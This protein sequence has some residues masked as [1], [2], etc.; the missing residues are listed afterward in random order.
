[1]PEIHL[2]AWLDQLLHVAL[3][4][5][6][7]LLAYLALRSTV[8]LA[9]RHLLERRTDP[10]AGDTLSA[11][12][13]ERRVRTLERLTL[14]VAA[15]VIVIIAG[16]MVLSPFVDIGPAVAGFGVVG[17]AVGFGAQ[18][19]IKDWLA[20]IFVIIE[21]QYSQGDVVRIAGVDGV[22]E[23]FSLRRTVLRDLNGTV[24][25]VPNGQITV[26]SNMTR[27]WARVNLDVTVG[28]GTDIDL[29]TR[30]IND[31]GARLQADPEWAPRMLEAPTVVRVNELG[32]NGITLK[33]LG[34]VRAAEQWTV[35]GELRKRVLAV[36]AEHGIKI[37]FPQRV[38]ITQPDEGEST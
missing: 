26:A 14:R 22:V 15:V 21:N 31:I 25:S 17:I 20:G 18:T 30:L 6:V 5:A 23:D 32:Q 8:T 13:L 35:A 2:P 36:F 38:M 9:V 7:A 19:L 24:H 1:M 12:E 16:L 34:Q 11:I 3:I 27:V 28:Y 10:E 29:A 4:V 33:V 37:P